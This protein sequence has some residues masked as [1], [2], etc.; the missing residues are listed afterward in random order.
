LAE[1]KSIAETNRGE[2]AVQQAWGGEVVPPDIGAAMT[3]T[4][5]NVAGIHMA[6]AYR[7]VGALYP[8]IYELGKLVHPYV[9]N[10]NTVV[11]VYDS[12]LSNRV[13]E[14]SSLTATLDWNGDVAYWQTNRATD[15]FYK[16][17]QTNYLDA[18]QA[19]PAGFEDAVIMWPPTNRLYVFPTWPATYGTNGYAVADNLFG[20]EP[21]P[22]HVLSSP[23]KQVERGGGYYRWMLFD[24]SQTNGFRYQ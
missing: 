10:W 11:E 2:V 19:D 17:L 20:D 4:A 24:F 6:E 5:T 22:Y 16:I 3:R 12:L 21:Q 9:T 13:A 1:A 8:F 7:S 18:V 23:S 14:A 15:R